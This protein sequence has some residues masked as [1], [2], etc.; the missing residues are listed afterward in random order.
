MVLIDVQL[1]FYQRIYSVNNKQ[2][3]LDKHSGP[4]NKFI[5]LIDVQLYCIKVPR[6]R[7][8]QQNDAQFV[9]H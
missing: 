5:L 2:T 8:Q 6:H 4:I 3:F 7:V 9:E 1:W